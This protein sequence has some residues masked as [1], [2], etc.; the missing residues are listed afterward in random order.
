MFQLLLVSFVVIVAGSVEEDAERK[1]N[2]PAG[3]PQGVS[4]KL[5]SNAKEGPL[6]PGFRWTFRRDGI[7]SLYVETHTGRKIDEIDTTRLRIKGDSLF[8]SH[9]IYVAKRNGKLRR[10]AQGFLDSL[11]VTDATPV[12]LLNEPLREGKRWRSHIEK[13]ESDS[14]T[15]FNA[16]VGAQER[17]K[18]PAGEFDAWSIEYELGY[19]LGTEHDFRI[20]YADDV[21]IVKIEKWRES[22]RGQKKRISKPIVYELSRVE[23]LSSAHAIDYPSKPQGV[24]CLPKNVVAKDGAVTL[25]ADYNDVWK[26]QVVLYIVNKSDKTIKIPTQDRDLY[27]KLETMTHVGKWKRAQTHVHS[28]CGN[29]YGSLYLEPDHFISALGWLPTKGVKKKVRYRFYSGSQ[30]ASNIGHALVDQEIVAAAQKDDMS[31]R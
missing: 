31:K 22:S 23:E 2:Q 14:S 19:H 3:I 25:F 7:D 17:I 8:W 4:V 30:I 10:F 13:T 12:V 29:S 24:D 15:E 18:V 11:F 16:T 9:E 21:G 27:I 28:W 5:S 20:W 26:N 1:L 6:S